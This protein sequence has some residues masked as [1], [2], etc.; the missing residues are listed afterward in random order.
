[1]YTADPSPTGA[2]TRG[3]SRVHVGLDRLV[4]GG[5][6]FTQTTRPIRTERC[7]RPWHRHGDGQNSVDP[8]RRHGMPVSTTGN[9]V[10]EGCRLAE[11]L[12]FAYF[13]HAR[14]G[15][16]RRPMHPPTAGRHQLQGR[17]RPWL[18]VGR[19]ASCG[20]AKSSDSRS[21]RVSRARIQHC[22]RTYTG[23]RNSRSPSR[24]HQLLSFGRVAEISPRAKCHR[25]QGI[26]AGRKCG[27]ASYAEYVVELPCPSQSE[28]RRL[29]RGDGKIF[30]N[31]KYSET[32]ACKGE[33][34][35]NA[36]TRRDRVYR[37]RIA[38]GRDRESSGTVG[39]PPPA[40]AAAAPVPNRG[41]IRR[42]W[43]PL[44]HPGWRSSMAEP[45]AAAWCGCARR[46]STCEGRLRAAARHERPPRAT[47]L[48]S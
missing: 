2:I 29:S 36:G 27:R 34:E 43:W 48:G 7:L 19:Q 18:R 13:G 9:C 11:G 40:A 1:M 42:G 45:R 25:G 4:V 46:R 47:L 15:N 31:K 26:S 38:A 22:G 10:P 5:P 39:R 6:A 30:D 3:R 41:D 21:N 35:R 24:C 23:Q 28:M 33:V 37:R 17:G 32:G 8:G 12:V 14:V 16:L 20:S 44:R